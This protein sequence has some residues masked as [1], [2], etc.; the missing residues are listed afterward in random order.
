[1]D[2]GLSLLVSF[3]P[4]SDA[5]IHLVAA[6]SVVEPSGAVLPTFGIFDIEVTMFN[7]LFELSGSL[8][9]RRNLYHEGPY[10]I[11][12]GSDSILGRLV[13]FVDNDFHV[14]VDLDHFLLSLLDLVAGSC[15]QLL[16]LR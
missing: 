1:V 11:D 4:A 15:V 13:E 9:Q 6:T 3:L 12:R 14:L 16:C 10:Q 7:L 5:D 2:L 8:D